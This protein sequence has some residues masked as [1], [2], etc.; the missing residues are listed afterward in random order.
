MTPLKKKGTWSMYFPKLFQ[1]KTDGKRIACTS[2]FLQ[3]FSRPLLTY[4]VLFSHFLCTTL[5]P[6][7]VLLNNYFTIWREAREHQHKQQ[8][9]KMQRTT[10]PAHSGL[11]CKGHTDRSMERTLSLSVNRQLPWLQDRTASL[12]LWTFICASAK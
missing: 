7:F 6:L 2:F 11:P 5:Q 8:D 9:C 12:Y 1:L 4:C 10:A 3:Y